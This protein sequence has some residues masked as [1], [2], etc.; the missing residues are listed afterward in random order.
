LEWT[1]GGI[2]RATPSWLRRQRPSREEV[3]AHAG[4]APRQSALPYQRGWRRIPAPARRRS[5]VRPSFP[6]RGRPAFWTVCSR[7]RDTEAARRRDTRRSPAAR[8]GDEL[9]RRRAPRTTRNE[10]APDT[11]DY[12]PLE[13][14]FPSAAGVV[15]EPLKIAPGGWQ[16]AQG[17]ALV[18]WLRDPRRE[19]EGSMGTRW[20]ASQ[21][22]MRAT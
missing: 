7:P 22:D 6:L 10:R 9:P 15:S 19:R 12:L 13:T 18:R 17:T 5:V 14:L 8:L 16:G 4:T 11:G 2:A 3:P 21:R 20:R 1:E